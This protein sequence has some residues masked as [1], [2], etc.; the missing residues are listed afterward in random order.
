MCI[1]WPR[2]WISHIFQQMNPGAVNRFLLF[3]ALRAPAVASAQGGLLDQMPQ[4]IRFWLSAGLGLGAGTDASL[5]IGRASASFS[6]GQS[7]VVVRTSGGGAIFGHQ[8]SETSALVGR[9]SARADFFL[10]GA[11]GLGFSDSYDT[12]DGPCSVPRND[13][14]GIVFAWDTGAHAAAPILGLAL[15]LF[16]AFGSHQSTFAGAVV[17]VEAGWFGLRPSISR[18]P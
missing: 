10:T 3:C 1:L 15:H 6:S 11:V 14:H 2:R 17:T 13:R 7:L 16:G 8:I 9:R 18:G 5:L 4:P 12:C